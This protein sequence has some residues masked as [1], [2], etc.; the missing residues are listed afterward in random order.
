MPICVVMTVGAAGVSSDS[1]ASSVGCRERGGTGGDTET[2]LSYEPVVE[3]P[4]NYVRPVVI[5]GPLKDRINDDLI[6]EFPNN[7]ASC[8]PR[9]YQVKI[10]TQLG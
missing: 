8:V 6:S 10:K 2:V 9:K 1:E 7:F 3:T 4:I 5:L